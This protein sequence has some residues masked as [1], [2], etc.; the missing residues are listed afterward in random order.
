VGLL[1]ILLAGCPADP[2]TGPGN[3]VAVGAAATVTGE[4]VQYGAFVWG[5]NN[6]CG[7]DSLT[8]VGTQ[9]GG[10]TLN[11]CIVMPAD[12]MSMEVVD[13]VGV[14]QLGISGSLSG[15]CSFRRKVGGAVAA[16]ATVSGFCTKAGASWS[17]QLGGTV[18]G[19]KSCPAATDSDV[20]ITLGGVAVEV[21]PR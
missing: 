14:Q 5:L 13:L 6:D 4:T 7:P 11:F 18:A 2:C 17:L 3:A 15:G 16:T 1:V 20:T 8:V 10:G 9:Q 19:V 12:V 21:T